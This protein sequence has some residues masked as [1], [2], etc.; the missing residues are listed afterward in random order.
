MTGSRGS[1]PRAPHDE[2]DTEAFLATV[3]LFA[4]LP[5]HVRRE[6]AQASAWVHLAGGQY[7]FRQGDHADALALVGSGRLLV[8]DEGDGT[9]GGDGPDQV[10]GVLARGS[11]VGE[12]AL[13][14]GARRSATIQALR[15]SQL[16]VV[17]GC[18][19]ECSSEPELGVVT[20]AEQPAAPR[21]APRPS[22]DDRRHPTRRR[23]PRVPTR[24]APARHPRRG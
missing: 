18:A 7:L 14:T 16:L 10:I 15:D 2:A 19:A 3:P 23:A 22:C 13:L 5:T 20:S 11:W 6:L 17:P 24:G 21:I 1:E 12:L 4:S 9:L 8:I